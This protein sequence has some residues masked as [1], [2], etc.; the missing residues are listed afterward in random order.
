MAKMLAKELGYKHYSAGDMRRQ[1]AKENGITLAELNKIGETESW[2]DVD[3]DN[4]LIAMGKNEDDFVLDAKIA[5]YLVPHA[6]KIFLTASL[7]ERARR[8]F[9]VK[10]DEEKYHSI[11]EVETSLLARVECDKRRYKKYYDIN[12]YDENNFDFILDTTNIPIEKV[13]E[14]ILKKV[15]EVKENI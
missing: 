13:F 15:K 9:S 7:H 2:T 6:F 3:V 14:I 1:L 5:E 10:R 4:K 11:E 12:A 8:I